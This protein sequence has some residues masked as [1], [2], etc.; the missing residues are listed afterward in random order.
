MQIIRKILY[1]FLCQVFIINLNAL[2]A[3]SEIGLSAGINNTNFFEVNMFGSDMSE[4]NFIAKNSYVIRLHYLKSKDNGNKQGF[5]LE[6]MHK[7]AY[8][9]V[10]FMITHTSFEYQTIDWSLQYVNLHYVY[11]K[12]LFANDNFRLGLPLKPYIGGVIYICMNGKQEHVSNTLSSREE[13]NGCK[14][15]DKWYPS[16]GV[17]TGLSLKYMLD[18]RFGITLNPILELDLITPVNN[19]E[20]TMTRSFLITLG[21]IYRFKTKTE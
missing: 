4:D 10:S 1:L 20:C 21:V 2:H 12:Q 18:D 5:M 7:K 6:Q 11:D 15:A 9:D 14:F 13:F 3:Q 19:S 17:S 8:S 16:L